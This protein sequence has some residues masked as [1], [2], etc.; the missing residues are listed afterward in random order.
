MKMSVPVSSWQTLDF[1]KCLSNDTMEKDH[2]N[3]FT[4]CTIYDVTT[5]YDGA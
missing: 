1:A 3:N 2:T 4:D 5:I